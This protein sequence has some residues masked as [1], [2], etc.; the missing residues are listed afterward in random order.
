MLVL[1]LTLVL[2]LTLVQLRDE[3]RIDERRLLRLLLFLLLPFSNSS[4]N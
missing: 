1:M 4:L 2:R 3:K